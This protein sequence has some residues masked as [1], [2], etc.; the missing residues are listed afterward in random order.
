[1]ANSD[2]TEETPTISRVYHSELFSAERGVPLYIPTPSENSPSEYKRRGIHIGDVG[3]FREDGSFD[4]FFSI[5]YPSD[6]PIN[7]HRGVPEGFEVYTPLE[8][9]CSDGNPSSYTAP[10]QEKASQAS[11]TDNDVE[12]E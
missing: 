2:V 7:K 5:A 12:S 4:Y 1:M 8:V 6:D 3:V 10:L 9:S 11:S